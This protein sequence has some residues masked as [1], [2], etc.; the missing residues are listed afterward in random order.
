MLVVGVEE[1]VGA[2]EVGCWVVVMLG[3]LDEVRD[4]DFGSET[5]VTGE[6][7]TDWVEDVDLAVC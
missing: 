5:L 4:D 3:E 6:R 7:A 2:E 1:P